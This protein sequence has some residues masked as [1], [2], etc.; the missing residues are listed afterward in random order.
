MPDASA[1]YHVENKT[2]SFSSILIALLLCA[3]SLSQVAYPDT[4]QE[5]FT[6]TPPTTTST[7]R[8]RLSASR[9]I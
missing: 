7:T 6:T 9:R 3:F 2:I 4:R 1:G 5:A 8:H